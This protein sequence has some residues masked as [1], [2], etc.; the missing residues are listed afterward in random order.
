MS[1]FNQSRSNI[2]RLIF[3]GMFLVI[4]AQLFHLQIISKKYKTLAQEQCV[5]P[6]ERLPYPRDHL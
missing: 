6:E 4:A 5:V 2:I 3:A 1:V